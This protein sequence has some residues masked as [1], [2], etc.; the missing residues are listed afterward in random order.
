MSQYMNNEKD[1]NKFYSF[2][3]F[4]KKYNIKNKTPKDKNNYIILPALNDKGEIDD[5]IYTYVWDDL[6]DK[7]KDKK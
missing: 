6:K 7:N 3:D 5:K 1:N 4:L 2:D